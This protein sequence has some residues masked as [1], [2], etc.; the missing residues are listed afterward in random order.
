[1]SHFETNDA[2]P[3]LIPCEGRHGGKVGDAGGG[4]LPRGRADGG[5]PDDEA[6]FRCAA[7]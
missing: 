1:M 6:R 3:I 4:P 7:P 5:E 2:I